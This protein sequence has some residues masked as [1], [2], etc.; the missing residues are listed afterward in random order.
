MNLMT[1]ASDARIEP[2]GDHPD[3]VALICEWH[4]REFDPTGDMDFW[5]RTRTREVRQGG[6]PCAWIAFADQEPIGSVS[7]VESNMDTRKDLTP[8]LAALFVVPEHRGRGIGTA[9]VRRCEREAAMAGF[10][11]LYLYT[12][13]VE[14][15]RRLQWVVLAEEVYEGSPWTIMGKDLS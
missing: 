8:W 1:D 7:L 13:G 10:A 5:L 15:Y 2:L 14:Y 4:L 6:V 3:L 9:L 12:T 11:R